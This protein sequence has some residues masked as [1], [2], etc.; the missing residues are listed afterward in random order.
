MKKNILFLTSV[1]G[2]V[3][4]GLTFGLAK[5]AST[6]V[7][8]SV[9]RDASAPPPVGMASVSP[10]SINFGQHFVND[11]P[12][13]KTVTLTNNGNSTMTI[14]SI[15]QG[16]SGPLLVSSKTCGSTLAANKSCT[17][18]VEFDTPNAPDGTTSGSLNIVDSATNSPQKVPLSGK[19]SCPGHVCP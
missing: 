15:G 8:P 9:H 14:S 17:I 13:F 18:T 16:L 4:C 7:P 6:V 10:T 19:R 5:S 12:V 3:V 2:V 11:P 1:L